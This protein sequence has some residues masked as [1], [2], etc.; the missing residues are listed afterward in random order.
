MDSTYGSAFVGLIV[1]AT[2]YGATILQANYPKDTYF[3]KLLGLRTRSIFDTI[4]L[5]LCITAMYWYLITNYD[6]PPALS[7]LTWSMELQTDCNGVIALL[8]EWSYWLSY[9]LVIG[10]QNTPTSAD[11]LIGHSVVLGIVFTIDSFQLV[12]NTEFGN[13]IWV[14]S[15]GIGSAAAADVIIAGALC[16]YLSKSRTGFKNFIGIVIVVTFA[17]MPN[18]YIWLAFFWIDGKCYVNSCLAARESLREKASPQDGS[19]LQLSRVTANGTHISSTESRSDG[20]RLA[21]TVHTDTVFK[22]DYT[23]PSASSEFSVLERKSGSILVETRDMIAAGLS[24]DSIGT[25]G[26]TSYVQDILILV[27]EQSTPDSPRILVTAIEACVY[28][29]P[30]TSCA[31]LYISKVDSTGQCTSPSPTATLVRALLL[32]YGDQATR[33]VAADHLWIQLFARAQSQY[34]FPN[35]ADFSGKHP[36]GDIQLCG[37]WKRVFTDAALELES[38]SK[39]SMAPLIRLFYV[40]PGYSEI[41]AEHSLKPVNVARPVTHNYQWTYGHPYSQTEIPL[42]C[43]RN[44]INTDVPRNLGQFIPSFDDDPK[45]RFM[46]EI[47]Y[48]TGPEGIKSPPRKRARAS[49]STSHEEGHKLN[50]AVS[51]DGDDDGERRDNHIEKDDRPLGELGKVSVDEFWERMSFRQECVAGAV[52]GFFA[53]GATSSRNDPDERSAVSSLKPQPG[54]VS[55]K[56]NKR[57]ITSLMTG[58]EFSTRERAIRATELIEGT[59]RGLCEGISVVPAPV[60]HAP[61]PRPPTSSS[62]RGLTNAEHDISLLAPPRTPPR[63]ASGKRIVPDVSPNPFPEPETSLETYQ[64]F[65]YGSVNISNPIVQNKDALNENKATSTPPVTILTVRRKKKRQG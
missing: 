56:M 35:S 15:A 65:I 13:L 33:P 8:V 7:R 26:Q 4:Q 29:V 12:S 22:T 6:N 34:L 3:L 36:L 40:L 43:P 37:W 18:D 31:I 58:V 60:I 59:I 52:T 32:Y 25:I 27:S 46:D 23:D 10:E 50:A 21:I 49:S 28:N 61:R 51:N 54:Q 5:V 63:M 2:L 45:S 62:G 39:G 14:T 17:T 1:S 55:S 11:S 44:D 64:L 16:F 41:E 38:C 48:T 20:T 53:L 42:P 19:F 47:A 30:S 9:T 24:R 57:V